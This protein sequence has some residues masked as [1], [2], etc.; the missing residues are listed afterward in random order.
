MGTRAIRK[1]NSLRIDKKTRLLAEKERLVKRQSQQS[2]RLRKIDCILHVV[3][4]ESE[5]SAPH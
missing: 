2:E 5:G 3:A 1:H 4:E